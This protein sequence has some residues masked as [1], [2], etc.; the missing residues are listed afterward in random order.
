MCIAN[1]LRT[2]TEAFS[3][4]QLVHL[5]GYHASIITCNHSSRIKVN[6]KPEGWITH[7]FR[8]RSACHL[9]CKSGLRASHI[10]CSSWF[11]QTSKLEIPI[12][13]EWEL[14]YD[15][16]A[17]G[18]TGWFTNYPDTYKLSTIYHITPHIG[19]CTSTVYRCRG[20]SSTGYNRTSVYFAPFKIHVCA[21]MGLFI[22]NLFFIKLRLYWYKGMRLYAG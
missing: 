14:I 15:N 16:E 4:V 19:A 6:W 18:N 21:S 10:P 5:N 13:T 11:L 2:H 1:A 9:P 22:N 12:W 17:L 8:N 20:C 3:K 7:H